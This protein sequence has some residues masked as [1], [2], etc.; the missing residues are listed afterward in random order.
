LKDN[1]KSN[2]HNNRSQTD[3]DIDGKDDNLIEDELSGANAGETFAQKT[4]RIRKSSPN[5]HLPNWEL[6]GLICKS[7]D[8]LRQEVSG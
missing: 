6:D 1:D 2:D 8:D 4:E 3:D 5:S 7:N